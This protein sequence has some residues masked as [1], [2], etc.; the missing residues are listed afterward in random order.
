[1]PL[2]RDTIIILLFFFAIMAIGGTNLMS[3]QLKN[4]CINIQSGTM[5]PDEI[6]CYG[7]NC[8][9]GFFCGKSNDNPNYGVTNFDNVFYSLL[10]VFQSVTLEGWSDVQSMM[11]MAYTYSIWL[12]FLP[13]VFIGAFFLLNLTLAAYSST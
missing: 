11:Q 10:C 8:P 9:G 12:Y 6:L 13:L 5:H 3:G 1:M 4:R 2:L 7:S